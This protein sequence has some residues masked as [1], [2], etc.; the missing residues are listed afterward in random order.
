MTRRARWQIDGD[1]VRDPGGKVISTL[2]E[3]LSSISRREFVDRLLHAARKAHA[4]GFE[5]GQ[6]NPDG[7][8]PGEP[9]D[10]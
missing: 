5:E 7:V 3:N 4:R 2:I 8:Y 9:D 1:F 6:A 10:L